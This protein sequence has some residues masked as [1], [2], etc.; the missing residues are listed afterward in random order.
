M[1]N[2]FFLL[3]ALAVLTVNP[4]FSQ[5]FER[6]MTFE[7]MVSSFQ[8]FCPVQVGNLFY[9]DRIE[10]SDN[11]LLISLSERQKGLLEKNG[12]K[13]K[14]LKALSQAHGKN[15]FEEQLLAK[16]CNVVL[17]IKNGELF[18][19][20]QVS[21]S[22]IK[23]CLA[24]SPTTESSPSE[25][26]MPQ[27]YASPE[28]YIKG[29]NSSCP[30]KLTEEIEMISISLG[31][32]LTAELMVSNSSKM[33]EIISDLGGYHSKVLGYLHAICTDIYM[34]Y[35]FSKIKEKNILM[36]FIF[37]DK[38]TGKFAIVKLKGDSLF[39]VD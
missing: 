10:I 29:I 14:F 23:S 11:N 22:E 21:G 39:F 19:E 25:F 5:S 36:S 6:P 1:K 9:I 38:K 17:K 31:K 33:D 3:L 16:G 8:E 20:T 30:M 13:D 28:Y 7:E 27:I 34:H 18:E 26:V 12:L 24:S 2:R 37:K 32:I 4:S 35:I 15:P